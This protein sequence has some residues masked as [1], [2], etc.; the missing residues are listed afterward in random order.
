MSNRPSL[1]RP[2]P[3]FPVLGAPTSIESFGWPRLRKRSR[4]EST[5]SF[6]GVSNDDWLELDSILNDDDLES[7]VLFP[8]PLE[9]KESTSNKE[10]I[11]SD[12]MLSLSNAYFEMSRGAPRIEAE[13]RSTLTPPLPP[14]SNDFS[15]TS[16]VAENKAHVIPMCTPQEE[17]RVATTTDSTT[18]ESDSEV[19]LLALTSFP[20]RIFC[21]DDTFF[22]LSGL[23]SSNV[24]GESLLNV[25]KSQGS[26]P[27]TPR[28]ME[29]PWDAFEKSGCSVSLS[30][31]GQTTSAT[32]TTT[33]KT[34]KIEPVWA[35][36]SDEQKSVQISHYKVTL[37]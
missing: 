2:A 9:T 34:M 37:Q 21:A 19:V 22:R 15:L 29:T 16:S 4:V 10:N 28:L 1:K 31:N 30:N 13:L 24:I 7:P 14:P 33:T 8:A 26:I 36:S 35:K 17:V 3:I 11:L 25:F 23:T 12:A 6:K 5:T 20:F 27:V 18:K 32:T